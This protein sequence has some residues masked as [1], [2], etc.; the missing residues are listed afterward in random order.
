MFLNSVVH[1]GDVEVYVQ[2]AVHL[3]TEFGCLLCYR[4]SGSQGRVGV[5]G[6]EECSL[7]CDIR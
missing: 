5:F 6:G 1:T 7:V 2:A 3:C 4:L